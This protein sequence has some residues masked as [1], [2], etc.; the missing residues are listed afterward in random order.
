MKGFGPSL[1]S[2]V[3]ITEIG[4]RILCVYSAQL[5]VGINEFCTSTKSHLNLSIVYA[6][7]SVFPAL[8]LGYTTIGITVDT[9]RF[10]VDEWSYVCRCT[11]QWAMHY[12]FY[13]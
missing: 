5:T 11:R 7:T 6:G 13:V 3:N 12:G 8:K 2:P 1:K 4:K 10:M 9:F